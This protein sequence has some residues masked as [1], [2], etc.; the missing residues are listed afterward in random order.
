ML[1]A[2]IPTPCLDF[3]DN[4][5]DIVHEAAGQPVVPQHLVPPQVSTGSLNHIMDP[6]L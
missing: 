2:E 4:G 6:R 3:L 5:G 1:Y